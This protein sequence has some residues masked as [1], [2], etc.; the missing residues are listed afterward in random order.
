MKN[1]NLK[2]FLAANSCEGFISRFADCYN[3]YDNWKAYIIKG[4]PGTGKSSFMKKIAKAAEENNNSYILCPCSSDPQSLDAVILPDRK[5]V[6]LD[7]TAPHTLDPRYPAVCEEI[8]NFGQFWDAEKIEKSKEIIEITDLNKALH[9]TAS[10]YLAS[11]GQILLD[12][13]KTALACTKKV[14][15]KAFADKLC[16]RYIPKKSGTPYE[17]VRFIGG[18]T[19][20]GIVTY[21]ETI[22]NSCERLIIIS[23]KYHA[24]SNILMNE[25]RDYCLI[26]GYEIT[27]LKN[28]FLPT[29]ITDH[30]IIPELKLGFATED[31]QLFFNTDERRIHARRFTSN[32]LLHNSISRLKLNKKVSNSLILAT[33]DTLKQAKQVHDRLES[34]YI[35]AMD[36]DALN[37]FAEKFCKKVFYMI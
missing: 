25:I 32:K 36:F 28:P 24:C 17:W 7:G 33:A 19:P 4:G 10:R 30:I 5:I 9:K 23:D 11:A 15:T 2:Y 21:P 12:S 29:L 1:S 13:Y 34:Y 37:K 31:N 26:N 16:K 35:N 8:L 22:D 18:I 27:T 14:E 20:E 6:V 3:P